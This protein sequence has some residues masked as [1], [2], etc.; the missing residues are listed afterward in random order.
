MLGLL[1]RYPSARGSPC[2]QLG[3]WRKKFATFAATYADQHKPL[4]V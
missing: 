1:A 4:W 2:S 3:W